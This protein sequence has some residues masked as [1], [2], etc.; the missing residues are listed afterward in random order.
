MFDVDG[1]IWDSTG[2]ICRA[3][4]K[5]LAKNGFP[6]TILTPDRLKKEFG[7][8]LDVIGDDL[9][10]EIPSAKRTAILN[11]WIT[12]QAECILT[13]V[14]D[15]YEGLEEALEKLS[16]KYPLFVIS[17]SSK[18]YIESL[19]EV[20]GLDKYFRDHVCN[21]DTGLPKDG[22][23]RYMTEKHSLLHP[24]YVGDIQGDY[25][26]SRKAGAYFIHAAYGFG[27]VSDWDLRID[28]PLDLLKLL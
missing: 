25:E 18:G 20:T 1:T 16:E 12:V 15:L 10:P 22:N 9:L 4:N 8:P 24:A 17:N 5:V 26:A 19:Y 11:Q 14:P 27:D 21:G 2:P 28:K 7:K 13:D 23:I 6:S 3:W